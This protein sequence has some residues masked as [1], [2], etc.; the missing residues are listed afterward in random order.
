MTM[1]GLVILATLSL[2]FAVETAFADN[3]TAG[4]ANY[5]QEIW[6]VNAFLVDALIGLSVVH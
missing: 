1:Y 5:I 4:D 6:G 2:S 3:V